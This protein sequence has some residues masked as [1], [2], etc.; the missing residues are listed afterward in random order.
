LAAS[1]RRLLP[2]CD[3]VITSLDFASRFCHSDDLL[4]YS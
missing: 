4:N 3:G 2:P 1:A